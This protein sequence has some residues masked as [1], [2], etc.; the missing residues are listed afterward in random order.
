MKFFLTLV[1]L[2]SFLI[3]VLSVHSQTGDATETSPTNSTLRPAERACSVYKNMPESRILGGSEALRGEFTWMAALYYIQKYSLLFGCGGTIIS[4][5]FI[6]TSAHCLH[7]SKPPVLVRLGKITLSDNEDDDIQAA[8]H[9][10]KGVIRHPNYSQLTYQ[11][12]IGLVQVIRTI[13]FTSNLSPACLNTDIGDLGELIATGWGNTQAER[14]SVSDKLLKIQ[15]KTMPLGQC[16]STMLQYNQLI[17]SPR[18]RNGDGLND[19]QYCA[20]DPEGK[21]DTCQGDGGSPLQYF[22]SNEPKVAV[23]V[24]IS[25]FGISCGTELPSIYTRVGYYLDWIEPIVWPTDQ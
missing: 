4:P 23:I 3:G 17:N 5:Q 11:N 10:I 21:K 7:P 19:G 13:R 22:P 12:D 2:Q 24:G 25:S 8:D 14:S 9:Q 18:F 20:F 6:L 15:L 16:N 1:C